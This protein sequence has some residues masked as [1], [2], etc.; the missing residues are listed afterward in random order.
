MRAWAKQALAPAARFATRQCAR[1]IMYH[2]FS[3]GG[4]GG[5]LDVQV[6]DR[7][8]HYLRRHYRV[9]SL[10]DVIVRLKS[11]MAP[12]PYSVA[13]T[14][15]DAYA[16]FGDVAY[17]VFQRHGVPVTL[18]VVSEF[19]RGRMW[20]WWDM[21]RQILM[22]APNGPY[23]PRSS[24]V[25]LSDVTSRERAWQ[26]L[27][28][29]GLALSPAERQGYI[30]SLQKSFAV[31]LPDAPPRE[32]AALSW[33]ELRSLD[34]KLVEIGAHTRTHPILSRCEAPQIENEVAG[35]KSEIEAEL[36][37]EVRSF[38]YPNGTW[39]DVDARC[40]AAV[41]DAGYEGAVMACGTLVCRGANVY[42]L[43]R[44]GAS[45][46]WDDFAS[47]ISGISHLRRRALQP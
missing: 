11:G 35:S 25:S 37:R 46:R 4:A 14:V 15:D 6:L 33:D 21:I 24:S 19:A 43:D 3:A 8:L 2:R 40:L 18:Y 34:P 7:Q 20:L 16:D 45:E 13:V 27:A 12:E 17:P 38:C 1:V 29:V 9:V 31:P 39:S 26:E 44:V 36:G 23:A 42:A 32:F 47:E 22:S 10:H 5:R 28:G 41:R 30:D